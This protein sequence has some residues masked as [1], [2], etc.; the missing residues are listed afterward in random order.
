MALIMQMPGLQLLLARAAKEIYRYS[1]G[2]KTLGVRNVWVF[3]VSR[4]AMPIADMLA[5]FQGFCIL[6]NF[7][8]YFAL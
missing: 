7:R 2:F 6:N 1:D 3:A 8:Q 5:P 4:W